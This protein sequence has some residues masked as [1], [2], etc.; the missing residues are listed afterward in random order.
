MKRLE[1]IRA[2]RDLKEGVD[3]NPGDSFI[4]SDERASELVGYRLVKETETFPPEPAKAPAK[5]TRKKKD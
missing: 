5:K 3:R 2:F 4:A 1:T